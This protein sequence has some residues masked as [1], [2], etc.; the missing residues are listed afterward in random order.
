MFKDINFK[1]HYT[2]EEDNL[3]EDFYVPA[4]G[5]AINYSRAVGF[6]STG[7]ILNTPMALSQLVD[8]DGKIRIIFA[9]LVSQADL[10]QIKSGYEFDFVG[11]LPSFSQMAEDNK[12]S[13]IEY[14]IKLIAYLFRKGNL[15]IKIALRR[16]GMFHQ[17]IGI[18]EDTNGDKISFSG[19][20][21]E[22][23]SAL[24][25]DIN[26]EE[27]SVFK[28]WIS[29][30]VDYLEKHVNDFEKLWNNNSS[31]NTVVVDLPI[32][33][34][35][36]LDIV[37][38]DLKFRPSISVE[39]EL[40][41]DFFNKQKSHNF[42][43]MVPSEINGKKFEIRLHQKS[44]LNAWK[45]NNF[46]G[47]LELATGTG[48]TVTAIYAIAQIAKEQ[49][50][51]VAIISVP[52]VDL[53]DQWVEELKLFNI[54]ALR[55]YG[56]K[57]K[58]AEK[59]YSYITR[60]RLSQS[61]FLAIVVVNKTFKTDFFKKAI[62]N[63]DYKKVIFIGDECHHH[64][65]RSF[66]DFLPR[67]A[68]YKLGLS[69][70]PFHYL[71]N[72]A[73]E[74]LKSFYGDVVYQYSL[75]EAINNGILTQYE[76]Y[77]IP[78]MLTVEESDEYF[79]LSDKIGRMMAATG[80]Q[81]LDK[82]ERLQA[83]FMRRS[84]LIGTASNKLGA[85]KELIDKH[86]VSKH[87]LVYCSDG[88]VRDDYVDDGDGDEF[89]H[90]DDDPEIKQRFAVGRLLRSRGVSASFFTADETPSQRVKILEDFKVGEIDALVAIK[91]L[92]EGID[93]PACSTAYILAS[94]KNPRQFIQR[95]GRILRKAP[96]KDT[97]V[98]Y[99]FVVVLPEGLIGEEQKESD[100][101]QSELLR[102]GDFAKH[103][104]NH[105]SSLRGLEWWL[106]K[107]DLHHLVV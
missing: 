91:C 81:G 3:Y 48:K 73:N 20:M 76:Y 40:L 34:R 46:K 57:N 74:R 31:E 97:A 43:P 30:Q 65:S 80:G 26:S 6:F 10:D 86:G 104:V 33:L 37:S 70:T 71:D 49:Q 87:S 7:I 11:E 58:W 72:E 52:Y 55:C 102:V 45:D 82:D 44:A 69:A 32:G 79:N 19:S 12:G 95:R 64:M 66:Y 96:G 1:F 25:P 27:I 75:Y 39:R 85:L 90:H 107:Y 21:N 14:R 56:A 68:R 84:R 98:I 101:F 9:K 16:N 18:M 4:L 78:V 62:S 61:E 29:G 51:L 88:K 35:R 77:P 8:R 38:S 89:A 15:E 41:E 23:I 83:L 94:S 13:I 63:L 100:F 54:L 105:L 92:D 53:A 59:I 67:D 93:V 106:D 36:E 5:C 28:S 50:G 24:D 22:T 47:I 17:K 42:R 99:D 60:N 103:S 2:S